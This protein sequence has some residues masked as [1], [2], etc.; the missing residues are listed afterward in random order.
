MRR[1]SSSHVSK[2]TW[3]RNGGRAIGLVKAAKPT[4]HTLAPCAEWVKMGR[5][6]YLLS[7]G[8]NGYKWVKMDISHAPHHQYH[9]HPGNS[10]N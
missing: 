10:L 6:G 7:P 9:D 4:G 2:D 8:A 5:N 1:M 3:K